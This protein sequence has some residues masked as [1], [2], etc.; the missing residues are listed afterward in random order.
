MEV[1]VSMENEKRVKFASGEKFVN[2]MR[3]Q[4]FKDSDALKELIDNSLDA[5]SNNIHITI[6]DDNDVNIMVQDDGVGMSRDLIKRCAA[7]GQSDNQN[8]Q[9]IGRFGFGLTTA[10]ISRTKYTDIFSNSGSGWLYVNLNLDEISKDIGLDLPL[11]REETPKNNYSDHLIE[12]KTGT[13]IVMKKC[14]NVDFKQAETIEKHVI[15]DLEETYR[16]FISE[17]INIFV[18]GKK[19]L[20]RDPLMI[21][22]NHSFREDLIKGLKKENITENSGYG[23]EI[24]EVTPIEVEYKDIVTGEK[25]T[26]LVRVKI[27]L[28][29]IE[30]IYR[31]GGARKYK[32][33]YDSQGFYLMRNKRQ[34]AGPTNLGAFTVHPMLTHFRG[35][36]DF[37]A[38]LDNLFGIQVNKSRFQLSKSMKDKLRDSVG[39][40]ITTVRKKQRKIT[41]GLEKKIDQDIGIAEETSS[42]INYKNTR[43]IKEATEADAEKA[44]SEKFKKI[45]NDTRLN[46]KA[47]DEKKMRLKNAVGKKCSFIMDTQHIR[48]GPMFVWDYLGKTTEV[49]INREHPF[50][51]YVWLPLT[52]EKY[53]V[54]SIYRRTVLKMLMFSLAKGEQI[55]QQLLEDGNV[56]THEE[57]QNHWD[58][59]MRKFLTGEKFLKYYNEQ[60]IVGIE[61]NDIDDEKNDAIDSVSE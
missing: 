14:D 53:K 2:S 43:P 52:H 37:D 21:M 40:L 24:G 13:V 29:P 12:Y 59:M 41:T 58:Q 11:P 44:L 18:N 54:S 42:G 28:L 19:L 46:D 36:I 26:G 5:E 39:P 34:I 7:F 32:V 23:E 4:G 6:W 61:E 49:V 45:D 17:G 48:Q 33:G 51:R 57:L 3:H 16:I 56:I 55:H 25:K 30:D 8:Q 60:G 1:F 9:K 35:E 50:Y 31:T 10:I 22:K 20:P 47:K 38:S 15:P 27:V